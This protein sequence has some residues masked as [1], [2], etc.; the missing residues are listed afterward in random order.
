MDIMNKIKENL[1]SGPCYVGLAVTV[2]KKILLEVFVL[3]SSKYL[4][5][6]FLLRGSGVLI[7]QGPAENDREEGSVTPPS[8]K[9]SFGE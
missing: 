3:S 1:E 5:G 2:F 6:I 8:Q 7:L 4:H 9:G